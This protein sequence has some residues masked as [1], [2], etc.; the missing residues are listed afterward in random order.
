MSDS[1]DSENRWFR[2]ITFIVSLFFLG[3]S[4]LNAVWYNRIRN[5]SCNALSKRD[6]EIGFW[7]NIFL[8]II[9]GIIFIWALI[10]LF[11]FSDYR[12]KE[13]VISNDEF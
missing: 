6:A 12:N 10:S 8:A 5:G 3:I 13:H 11:Y 7:L 1:S 9:A 4:I 2:I